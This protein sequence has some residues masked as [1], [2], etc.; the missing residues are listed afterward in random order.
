VSLE[1]ET[2]SNE[3][4]DALRWHLVMTKPAN[5]E[6]AVTH[7]ERQGYGVYFPRLLQK[8]LQRGKWCDRVVAL[9]P[10]YV[11]VQLDAELQS[12]APIRSTL[13]VAQV[14]RFGIDYMTVPKRIIDNLKSNECPGT[15]LHQLHAAWFRPGDAVRIA[16]G[17]LAGLEGIFE[18][19]DG[20]HRVIVLLNLLGRE[21]RIQLDAGCVIPNAA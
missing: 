2:Q 10:R 5:E 19:D 7:L 8:S 6:L 16:T 4:K 1:T 3:R 14:V 17:S 12:L 21:T 18:S 15:G 9:F 20:N 11:F 13:G